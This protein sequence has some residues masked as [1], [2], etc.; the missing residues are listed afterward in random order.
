MT[1]SID[2]RKKVLSIKQDQN[3]SYEEASKFFGISKTTI[4]KWKRNPEPKSRRNKPATKID[5][6]LLKED[7]RKYPDSYNYERAER[8]MVSRNGIYYA[9]KRLKVSYKKSLIHPKA[10]EEERQC[11]QNKISEY[12]K[13]GKAVVYLDESGFANSMP[14]THGYALKGERC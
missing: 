6:E 5:M 12:E 9:L 8:L 2:F 4:L 11:F 1:Y 13:R 3:M 7:I 10:K 14:R